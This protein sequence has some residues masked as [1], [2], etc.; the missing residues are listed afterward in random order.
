MSAIHSSRTSPTRS[1]AAHAAPALDVGR[2]TVLTFLAFLTV[3]SLGGRDKAEAAINGV[4]VTSVNLR[5]GPTTRYPVV[6][7]MPQSASLAVYGCSGD[8]SWCDVS[9]SGARG[10]VAASYIQV[11]YNGRPTV[12]T[13]SIAPAVGIATVAFSVA[14]WDA[15]YHSQPWHGHWNRYYG[16]GSR[17]VVAGC[18]DHGCGA[19]AVTR[20]PHGGARAA[21]G[22]CHDGNCGAAAVTRGPHGGGRAA[23]GGC[24][25]EK[26]GGASVTRG[27]LGNTRIRHGSFDRP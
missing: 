23:V 22:G 21:A 20:G 1:V 14:Y 8:R 7:V 27:P 18:G 26:C 19:A 4:A 5:A 24:G 9:W 11:F 15:H 12:L 13:A 16:G 2:I 25:P 17:S 6:I 3:I 10:W